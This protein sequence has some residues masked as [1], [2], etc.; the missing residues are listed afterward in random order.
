M[1]LKNSP[2]ISENGSSSSRIRPILRPSAPRSVAPLYERWIFERTMWAATGKASA[3]SERSKIRDLAREQI[4]LVNSELRGALESMGALHSEIRRV[5]SDELKE[6]SN[7]ELKTIADRRTR[8]I[9][10]LTRHNPKAS[11][12]GW[13]KQQIMDGDVA[14]AEASR[15]L[16]CRETDQSEEKARTTPSKVTD[17]GRVRSL[18]STKRGSQRRLI[19]AVDGDKI[20]LASG[21]TAITE[22]DEQSR[23]W[24][25][26]QKL[27]HDQLDLKI[28]LEYVIYVNRDDRLQI[29]LPSTLIF[30]SCQQTALKTLS[31]LKAKSRGR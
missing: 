10:E 15:V 11:F 12:R 22:W 8:A 28:G 25:A 13:L 27:Q 9:A 31:P 3:A 26:V 7:R 30:R 5:I 1:G 24:S 19:K 21:E 17:I 23:R 6:L 2:I 4:M 29:D 16:R 18:V 14:A 20:S